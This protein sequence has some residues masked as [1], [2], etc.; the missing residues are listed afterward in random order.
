MKI[1]T[2]ARPRVLDIHGQRVLDI[3]HRYTN[4]RIISNPRAAIVAIAIHHDGVAMANASSPTDEL[5]R[6]D[7]I[8][9]HAAQQDWLRFPYPFVVF[10]NGRTYYTL[11][12]NH[13][14]SQLAGRNH[15]TRGVAI[16]GNYMTRRPSNQAICGAATAILTT[17]AWS[18]AIVPIGKHADLALPAYPTSCCGNSWPSWA[19]DLHAAV[20][21]RYTAP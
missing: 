8:Y 6:L 19:K 16:A 12:L 7:A 2:I 21:A 1:I 10:P 20:L 17:Y 5:A 13:Q 15:K 4:D 18:R 14:P 3:R 11:N 9:N